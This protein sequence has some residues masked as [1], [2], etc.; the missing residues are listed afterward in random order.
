MRLAIRIPAILTASLLWLSLCVPD[1]WARDEAAIDD[2]FSLLSIGPESPQ[3]L[4]FNIKPENSSRTTIEPGDKLKIDFTPQQKGYLTVLSISS[5]GTVKVVFPSRSLRKSLVNPGQTY[6]LAGGKSHIGAVVGK[7]GEKGGT[8]FYLTPT[9]LTSGLDFVDGDASGMLG[10][11]IGNLARELGN[12]AKLIGFHRV[13]LP[14]EASPGKHYSITFGRVGRHP[15]AKAQKMRLMAPRTSEPPE[16][17][18]GQAGQ[19]Q[20][21][22]P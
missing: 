6:T 18:T 8:V 9:P 13:M 15:P 16:S 11:R 5:D 22:S 17:L 2:P 4:K 10:T 21:R 1:S 20:K 12:L 19:H 14:L 7:A 3:V